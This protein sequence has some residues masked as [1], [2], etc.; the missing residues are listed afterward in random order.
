[1]SSSMLASMNHHW[2][3]S[4][5]PVRGLSLSEDNLNW[6][7]ISLEDIDPEQRKQLVIMRPRY[8]ALM[9]YRQRTE[10]SDQTSLS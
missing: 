5:R 2:P 6:Q 8:P 1:M 7:Q 3:T 10:K 9:N 4:K